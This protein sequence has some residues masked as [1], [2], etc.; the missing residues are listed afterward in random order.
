[1]SLI[2]LLTILG[3]ELPDGN[4]LLKRVDENIGAETRVAVVEMRIATRRGARSVKVKSYVKGADSSF[5]EYLAPEREKGTKM[6]KL[7]KDL[8]IYTPESDRTIRI[9]GHMLRQSVS[10]SDLS[11]EDMMEDPRLGN[12]YNATTIG[13]D[14]VS[15]RP[16]W[17][18]ELKARS[19]EVAYPLR[20]VWIDQERYLILKEE[21][22]AK[23]GKLLKTAEVLELKRIDERWV[24][25][26]ARFKDMLKLGEGTE[27]IIEDVKF[28]VLIPSALFSK[29]S[30][31]R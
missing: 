13:A 10:G 30:L 16:V 8:W 9:S 23:G 28:N 20:R 15:S 4:L 3:A 12:L 31:R 25:T 2:F 5:V 7:G 1:M 19:S 18:V 21:R 11:Y 17:V 24:V 14:S 6:L 27:F 26:R 29:S 22:Y